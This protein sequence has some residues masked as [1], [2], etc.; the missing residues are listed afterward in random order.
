MDA[1]Y[2][3]TVRPAVK[4]PMSMRGKTFTFYAVAVDAGKMPPVKRPT[5]LT[6][7]TPYVIVMDKASAMINQ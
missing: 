7:D 2:F 5:E 6:P 1:P 3:A 4:I